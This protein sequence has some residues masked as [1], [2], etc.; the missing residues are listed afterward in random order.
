MQLWMKVM[1]SQK[2]CNLWYLFIT[3]SVLFNLSAALTYQCTKSTFLLENYIWIFYPSRWF[4]DYEEQVW[5]YHWAAEN[6][7]SLTFGDYHKWMNDSQMFQN[8]FCTDIAGFSDKAVLWECQRVVNRIMSCTPSL[9]VVTMAGQ[10]TNTVFNLH[11]W[12]SC[13]FF[14]TN[15][16]LLEG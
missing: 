2:Q 13:F 8:L 1:V 5:W 16:Y 6:E 11:A 7:F 12:M 14:L 10:P 4:S 15:F 9:S 3:L